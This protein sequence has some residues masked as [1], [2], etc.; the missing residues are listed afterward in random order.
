MDL[1]RFS[2]SDMFANLV[3]HSFW[4]PRIPCT[5]RVVW[6]ELTRFSNGSAGW[7]LQIFMGFE[8]SHRYP[9]VSLMLVDLEWF[10]SL[11]IYFHSF[12]KFQW[13]CM[14]SNAFAKIFKVED[15]C[16]AYW[17]FILAALHSVYFPCSAVWVDTLREWIC[18]MDLIGFHGFKYSHR[19]P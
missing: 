15:A 11:F 5:F 13:I 16:E 1:Q 10:V 12:H 9:W 3:K 8:N 14:V 19:F 2:K 7:I 18:C 17:T 6:F 4:W